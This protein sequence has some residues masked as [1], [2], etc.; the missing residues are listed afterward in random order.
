MD[1]EQWSR[2][3]TT[4]NLLKASA[5]IQANLNAEV[6]AQVLVLSA[7]IDALIPKDLAER[8]LLESRF[9]IVCDH[10]RPEDAQ[11]KATPALA[12]AFDRIQ[13]VWVEV[14]RRPR[15]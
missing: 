7:M 8:Q 14:I 9:K 12:A 1:A 6:Q 3:A 5:P 10:H 11:L 13:A 15:G 4:V 2:L